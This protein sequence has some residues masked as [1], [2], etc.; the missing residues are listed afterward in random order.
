MSFT[1]GKDQKLTSR[2]RI[3][4]LFKSGYVLKSFPIFLKYNTEPGKGTIKI[5]LSVPKRKV[6]SAVKRNRLKRQM[7]EAYRLNK[8]ALIEKANSKNIDLALFLIYNGDEKGDFKRIQEK[9]VLI[10]RQLEEKI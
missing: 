3:D 10:L 7:R 9:I 1:F 6:R 2:I 4:E 5:A 8:L